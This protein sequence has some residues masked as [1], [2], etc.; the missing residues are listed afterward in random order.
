MKTDDRQSKYCPPS[1]LSVRMAP[2]LTKCMQNTGGIEKRSTFR[3]YQDCTKKE[4]RP[5]PNIAKHRGSYLLMVGLVL[6]VAHSVKAAEIPIL[7]PQRHPVIMEIVDG[8]NKGRRISKSC[9]AQNQCHRLPRTPD[10]KLDPLRT[11]C[12]GVQTLETR[13]ANHPARN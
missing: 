11:K 13:L 9:G 12:L 5:N 7:I 2:D 1:V 10:E 6:L 4:E 8:I 3:V